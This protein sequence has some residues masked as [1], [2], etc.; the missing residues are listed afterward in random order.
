MTSKV[1]HFP[2]A[3]AFVLKNEGGY[4]PGNEARD[5]N[6]TNRGVTQKTY[7]AYRDSVNLPRRAVRLIDEDEVVHIYE[8]YWKDAHCES[9]PRKTAITVFDHAINAGPKEAIKCLQRALGVPADGY[10]GPM[11]LA[12]VEAA[13]DSG[14]GLVGVG[15]DSGLALRVCMERIAHYTRIAQSQR[16]R[17]NLYSWVNRVVKFKNDYLP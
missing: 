13:V 6:P 4:Y 8:R 1:D 10:A 2:E 12:A 17:P 16:L 7:D 15:A 3:L 9:L 14:L 11:T 5:P